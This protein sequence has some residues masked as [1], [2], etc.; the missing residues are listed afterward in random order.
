MAPRSRPSPWLC[1]GLIPRF[2]R[3][4][5]L[6]SQFQPLQT[7]R[8]SQFGTLDLKKVV[9]G[10]ILPKSRDLGPPELKFRAKQQK[11]LASYRNSPD[12]PTVL[13]YERHLWAG[14]LGWPD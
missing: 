3:F 12:I 9:K 8:A 10:N 7:A 5:G 6:R 4:S 14:L 13:F 11:S 1:I 2:H